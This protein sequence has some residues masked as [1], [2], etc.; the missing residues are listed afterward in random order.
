MPRRSG[1]RT[2]ELLGL[3]R[4]RA[5]VRRLVDELPPDQKILEALRVLLAAVVKAQQ[6]RRPRPPKEGD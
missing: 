1:P 4:L 6:T 3:V 5:R 2:P